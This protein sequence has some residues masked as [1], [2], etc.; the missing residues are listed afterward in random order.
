MVGLF[1][2]ISLKRKRYRYRLNLWYYPRICQEELNKNKEKKT[3][4]MSANV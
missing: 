3:P 2:N 4:T 1:V